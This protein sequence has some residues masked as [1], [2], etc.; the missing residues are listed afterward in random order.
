MRNSALVVAHCLAG[1]RPQPFISVPA[2]RLTRYRSMVLARDHIH[3]FVWGDTPIYEAQDELG[4]AGPDWATWARPR[5]RIANI[6]RPSSDGA[7]ST[8]AM[9]AT[10]AA[11][12]PI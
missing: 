7:R 4:W 8:I 9:S 3:S 1:K 10:P 5:A 12:R 11:I 2:T 6:A